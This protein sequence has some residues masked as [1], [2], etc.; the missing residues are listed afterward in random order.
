M[1]IFYGYERIVNRRIFFRS[2][3]DTLYGNVKLQRN[4]ETQSAYGK[5]YSDIQNLIR[6]SLKSVHTMW[7]PIR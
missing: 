4:D 1:L 2:V 6:F 7:S 5:C 3:N